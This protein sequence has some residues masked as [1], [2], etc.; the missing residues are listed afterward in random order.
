[1]HLNRRRL[2]AVSAIVVTTLS[3]GLAWAAPPVV[4]IIAFA[5]PPGRQR[6]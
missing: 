6:R 3:T 4:E 5:H 1:M 2:L